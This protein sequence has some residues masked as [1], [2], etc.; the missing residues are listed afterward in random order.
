M[1]DV[2]SRE[3]TIPIPADY[4]DMN[5]FFGLNFALTPIPRRRRRL[6]AARRARA[7]ATAGQGSPLSKALNML[8]FAAYIAATI[9]NERR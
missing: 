8:R 6:Q 1:Q 9:N 7:R 4:F 3:Q 2:M 5:S